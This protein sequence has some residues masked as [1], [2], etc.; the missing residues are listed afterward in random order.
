MGGKAKFAK[1]ESAFASCQSAALEIFQSEKSAP[2]LFFRAA[3]SLSPQSSKRLAV[4]KFKFLKSP[5]S[6]PLSDKSKSFAKS[7]PL[8]AV[9]FLSNVC[10]AR[11]LRSF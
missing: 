2:P 5:L 11:T 3:I 7:S 4:K 9:I 8:T 1:R 6:P 10:A